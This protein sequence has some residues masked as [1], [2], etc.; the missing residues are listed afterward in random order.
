MN[1]DDDELLGDSTREDEHEFVRGMVVPFFVSLHVI[2]TCYTGTIHFPR[3]RRSGR[4]YP[5]SF[6]DDPWA[7][8]GLQMVQIGI[9]SS[10]F[11]W[12]YL[13]NRPRFDQYIHPA[14]I[15]T[16]S[17]AILGLALLIMQTTIWVLQV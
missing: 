5:I 14:L 2:Y 16:V 9:A 13:A 1:E 7:F 6:T 12:F 10:L 11:V 8:V 17:I 4:S 15:A 3:G